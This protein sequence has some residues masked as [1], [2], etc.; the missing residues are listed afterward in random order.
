V[1]IH[2]ERRPGVVSIRS[3]PLHLHLLL[4]KSARLPRV[5]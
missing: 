5:R 1:V 4:G 3:G 2:V